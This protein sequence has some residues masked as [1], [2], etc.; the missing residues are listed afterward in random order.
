MK[1]ER[2][3]QVD[4][5][6]QAALER[7]PEGRAAFINEACR[8]DDSLR[9]EVEALLAAD[10]EAAGFIEAPAY[11]V[12]APLIAGDDMQSLVGKSIGHYHIISPIGKGGMG[13]VYRAR[14]AK[15][16]RTVA[17]KLLPGEVAADAERMRRFVREARAASALNHP[18][19][20]TIYEIGEAGGVSFIAMEYV[21]G[22]TLATKI[23]GQPL[24]TS[25]IVEIG[26]QIA[27]ALDEAHGK[28][29]THRD[30]KPAN[31]MLNE[32]GQVKVLD[33]GLAK[34]TRLSAQP[35]VSDIST[36]AKT[37][38]GVVMGTV[39]YMS[40]EQA[41]GREVDQRSDLFSLGIVLYEM[42]TGRLPFSGAN[43]SETLNL[44]LHVQPEA[45][46][47]FNY[48]VPAELERIVRK[49]LEK[50]RERR[51]QSARELLVDLKNLKRESEATA[52]SARDTVSLAGKVNSTWRRGIVVLAVLSLSGVGLA[53][54][55]LRSPFPPKVTASI[56]ITSDG[57][58]K[59][60]PLVTDGPRLYFFS[61]GVLAQVSSTGGETVE[62]PGS[63]P[64]THV[65][66]ISPSR[67]EL[68][69]VKQVG[70]EFDSP[71]WVFPVLGGAPRRLGNLQ[72]HAGTWS[73]DG[74]QIVYAYGHAL[75]IAKSDGTE[76]RELVTV[77]GRPDW[78]RWSPDGSRLRFTVLDTN[79]ANISSLWEVAA[80]GANPHPLLPGW[81]NPA[82]E[83]CGNWAADGRYF[84]FQSRRNGT[85]NIWA[86]RERAGLFQRAN[87]EP[88]QLTFGPLNYSAPVPSQDGKKLFVVG[89]LR[90]GELV[91]YDAKTQQWVSFLSGISAEHLDFSRDGEWVTYVSYPEGS[92]WRSKV[93]GSQRLQLS[94]PP[95][96][97]GLPRWS[98]DGQQIVF[99]ARLPGKGMKTYLV[100]A[101]GG[102]PQ[103][104]TPGERSELDPCWSPDG[105]SLVFWSG[106]ISP[107]PGAIYQLDLRTRQVSMVPGSE[108]LF[109]PRWSPDGRYIAANPAGRQDKLLLFDFTTQKWTELANQNSGYPHWSR[110]G[111]YIYFQS[112]DALFRVGIGDHKV[113]RLAIPYSFRRAVG[114][115]GG[116]TGWTPD[117]SPLALRDVGTQDIYALECQFP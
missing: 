53:Y 77:A 37:A 114:V 47:R 71:L 29:I 64:N 12:A 18:H 85:T 92:L 115:F 34:I 14:D 65:M 68:L 69:I 90:R 91:R 63:F 8:G 73:L 13:E 58:G 41:L 97:V 59:G 54:Y 86:M 36:L 28:G 72:G 50:E 10:G 117:D 78:P 44:I 5:L 110:D 46:A 40:P 104:Q 61:G 113:E 55:L 7:P 57:R 88:V 74:Q 45:M 83:C 1:P 22:Q 62:L 4:Q 67:A 31:V 21:E 43:T 16:D 82:A 2:W 27:D 9:R 94:F 51:Y 107:Q 25:E 76:P 81:N 32:R 80:D 89:E 100:L 106:G 39:P 75:Y 99:M 103:Q 79:I 116:W 3:Q 60:S 96:R 17:L 20:A 56:P 42:A 11:A 109:S 48:N 19:V 23:N 112:S 102:I 66:D 35:I 95:M 49:C 24:T 101:E 26:S 108:G 52:R 15:L 38:P 87:Q 70:S 84:V 111:K 33:F 98:P 105:N 30:I 93:D 6:F